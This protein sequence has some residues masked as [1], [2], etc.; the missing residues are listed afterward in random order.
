MLLKRFGKRR[1]MLV[2][3]AGFLCLTGLLLATERGS[4]IVNFVRIKL[5]GGFTTEE[6]LEMHGADVKSR[7]LPDFAAANLAFRPGRSRSLRSSRSG[8]SSCMRGRLPTPS[9]RTCALIP[10]LRKADTS[11]PSCARVTGK[12][13]K[14]ST[15]PNF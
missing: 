5:G 11:D 10:C 9:G 4:V 13:P 3:L 8:N 6:R 12:C 14:A 1:V 15:A 2:A 7:L